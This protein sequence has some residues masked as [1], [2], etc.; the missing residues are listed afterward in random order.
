MQKHRSHSA[1]VCD[2]SSADPRTAP[3]P[4]KPAPTLRTESYKGLFQVST[5][6]MLR[7]ETGRTQRNVQKTNASEKLKAVHVCV[8]VLTFCGDFLQRCLRTALP[9]EVLHHCLT[10][11]QPE[12]QDKQQL[13]RT[14]SAE[15]QET[16]DPQEQNRTWRRCLKLSEISK[17]KFLLQYQSQKINRLASCEPQQ[18]SEEPEIFSITA[19]AGLLLRSYHCSK[20]QAG[21]LGLVQS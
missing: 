15:I 9:P 21:V 14:G 3:T 10:Q 13:Q 12:G 4:R 11:Q 8:C 7:S 18:G 20:S 16:T 1:Y 5:K 2:G 6:P 19:A 17:S